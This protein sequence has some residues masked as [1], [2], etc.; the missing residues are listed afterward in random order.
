MNT[1]II[2]NPRVHYDPYTLSNKEYYSL[3]IVG[4]LLIGIKT[5][6]GNGV[7]PPSNRK[8]VPSISPQVISGDWS[9]PSPGRG[10]GVATNEYCPL[11]GLSDEMLMPS[12]PI[13]PDT[14]AS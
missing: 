12:T 11:P 14:L 8:G 10:D 7:S 13:F 4:K 5:Y 9:G 2:Y 6:A 1:Q 3:A